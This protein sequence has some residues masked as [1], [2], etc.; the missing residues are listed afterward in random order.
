MQI[1]VKIRSVYG[2]RRVYPVCDKA[3]LFTRLTGRK[4]LS[5]QDIEIIKSLGF[6]VEAETQSI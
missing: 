5:D 3:R 4:T 1:K 6:V 2:V